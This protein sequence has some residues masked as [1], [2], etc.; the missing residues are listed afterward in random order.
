MVVKKTPPHLQDPKDII[1]Y[2]ENHFGLFCKRMVHQRG[3][4]HIA[5]AHGQPNLI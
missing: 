1:K 5:M 4:C 2:S 3:G